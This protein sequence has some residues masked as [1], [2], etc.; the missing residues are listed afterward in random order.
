MAQKANLTPVDKY[1]PDGREA[2]RL[3]L[4]KRALLEGGLID[5]VRAIQP[6]PTAEYQHPDG[7][8]FWQAVKTMFK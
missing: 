3:D 5:P 4:K 7:L 2:E 6:A 1:E 8:S